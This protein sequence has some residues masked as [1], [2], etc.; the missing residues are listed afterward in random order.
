MTT[1]EA[2]GRTVRECRDKTQRATAIRAELRRVGEAL[3]AF[4]RALQGQPALIQ[5]GPGGFA[6]EDLARVVHPPHAENFN[7]VRLGE[8]I[9]ELRRLEESL[10]QLR[11]EMHELGLKPE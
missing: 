10:K 6:Y 11:R 5:L 9:G 3:A 8:L 4:G 1:D 2:I 7:V